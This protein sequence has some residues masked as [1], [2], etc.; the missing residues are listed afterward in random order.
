MSPIFGATGE[1]A[2]EIDPAALACRGLAE[3]WPW[4]AGF[5][6]ITPIPSLVL[7]VVLRR[8]DR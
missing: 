2:C 3:A 5:V 7:I 6:L 4:L 1:V 8:R